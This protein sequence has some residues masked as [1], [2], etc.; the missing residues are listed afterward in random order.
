VIPVVTATSFD[1]YSDDNDNGKPDGRKGR[2]NEAAVPLAI[3][4]D[5]ATAWTTSRYRSADGDGKG[6][7]GII[8]D[9]GETHSVNAVSIDFDGSGAEAEVRVADKVYRDPGTW[10]LLASAPAGG[11]SIE[12]RSPRPKIGR[13]VLLWFPSLPESP[14]SPGSFSLGVSGVEVRG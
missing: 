2:E 5:Q 13:Y 10:N 6:G 7:V 4:G 8:L 3:D 1:P 9:L 11:R 12:L 14:T